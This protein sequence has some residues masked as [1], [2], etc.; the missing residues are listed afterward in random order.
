MSHLP[1]TG[2]HYLLSIN[3]L[4]A[5]PN[6]RDKSTTSIA[7]AS[8]RMLRYSRLCSALLV[9]LITSCVNPG[10]SAVRHE[11]ACRLS[12]D[13]QKLSPTVNA[14]EADKLAVTA[15]EQSVKISRDYKPMRLPWLNNSL[16]NV[17]LR[18]RGLCYQW[19]NDLFPHLFLLKSKTLKLNLVTARRGTY[20]E[21]NSI[22]VTAED[23]TFERGLILDPWRRGGRLWWGRFDQDKYPWILLDRDLT[24][25]VLRPLL[26]P[27][28]YPP[29]RSTKL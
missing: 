7:P 25:M 20:L 22:V 28:H 10:T 1:I 19:R 16:V 15:V 11:Q 23:L 5:I 6:T 24:P 21:H 3:K 4:L 17:G 2:I 18:K 13:L 27:E 14:H 29:P 9:V 12:R 8:I 26:M